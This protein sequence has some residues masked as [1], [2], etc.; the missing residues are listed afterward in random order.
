MFYEVTATFDQNLVMEF[1]YIYSPTDWSTTLSYL[2]SS[3]Y[4]FCYFIF[5][6][7]YDLGGKFSNFYSTKFIYYIFYLIFTL[8]ISKQNIFKLIYFISNQ[9]KTHKKDSDY[10]KNAEY[11]IIGHPLVYSISH[12]NILCV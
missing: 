11:P 5:P 1:Q 9:K 3:T 12:V 6:I 10:R 8:Q 2:Y 7:H 4:I